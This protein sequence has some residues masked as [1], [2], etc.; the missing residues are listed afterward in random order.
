MKRKILLPC[1]TDDAVAVLKTITRRVELPVDE[2]CQCSCKD[3]K[4]DTN[5]SSSNGE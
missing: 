5:T 3:D 1:S 4:C 2:T